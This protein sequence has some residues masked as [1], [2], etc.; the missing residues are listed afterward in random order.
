MWRLGL[1]E[2]KL[3]GRDSEFRG[4]IVRVK[5]G[6]GPSSFMRCLLQRLFPLE[7]CKQDN[8]ERST[9]ETEKDHSTGNTPPIVESSTEQE[10][11]QSMEQSIELNSSASQQHQ[12]SVSAEESVS[13]MATRLRRRAA[14]EVRDCIIARIMDNQV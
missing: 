3:Q 4:A 9:C 13:T 6:Q 1:V 2:E 12:S 14:T 11:A 8:T 5:S 7:V 10:S